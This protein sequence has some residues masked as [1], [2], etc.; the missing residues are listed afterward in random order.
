[1]DSNSNDDS[2]FQKN[3][4]KKEIDAKTVAGQKRMLGTDHK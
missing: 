1:M 3:K 4:K 2:S